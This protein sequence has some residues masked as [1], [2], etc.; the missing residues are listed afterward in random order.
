MYL[1]FWTSFH[2]F[3]SAYL[4][5]II[6]HMENIFKAMYCQIFGKFFF[7]V[8]KKWRNTYK[9]KLLIVWLPVNLLDIVYQI[10]NI[11]SNYILGLDVMFLS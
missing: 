8:K 3:D 2:K 5:H 1:L 4:I 9:K 11:G 6:I 7:S 10:Q